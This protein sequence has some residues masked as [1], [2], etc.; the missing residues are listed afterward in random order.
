[1]GPNL[2]EDFGH[3]GRDVPSLGDQESLEEIASGDYLVLL[4]SESMSSRIPTLP[5]T[6]FAL[7][8][9]VRFAHVSAAGILIGEPLMKKSQLTAW[10]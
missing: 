9:S 7:V 4:K 2:C 3:R 6:S 10:L 1:M 5:R 8:S